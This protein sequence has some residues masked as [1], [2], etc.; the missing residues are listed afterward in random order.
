MTNFSIKLLAVGALALGATAC[1]DNDEPDIPV[2]E[3][4]ESNTILVVNNGVQ[5]TGVPGT[6]TLYN[7]ATGNTVADAF[8]E[9]N[10]LSIGDTPQ[11]AV[12]FG[13]KLY[14]SVFDSNCIWVLDAQSLEIKKSIVPEAPSQG[15]RN[16]A[17]AGDKVYV[18]LYSGHVAA[19]D[20]TAM[21]IES[22]FEV[23]PNPEKIAVRGNMMYVANSDGNNW[24]ES[25][26]NSSL[27]IV[28]LAT[29]EQSF[30]KIGTNVT[31]VVTNGTDVF[32]LCMG[33]YGDIP[34]TIKK[35]GADGTATDFCPGTM[36]AISGSK[37]YVINDPA[38]TPVN[39]TYKIYTTAGGVA[40]DMFAAGT[41]V[42]KAPCGISINNTD[43]SFIILSR[44]M[45]EVSPLYTDPGVAYYY[46][47]DATLR[48]KFDIGINPVA[49]LF[50]FCSVK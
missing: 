28:D 3:P 6:L 14:I 8:R 43:G 20:T 35:I 1:S 47:S 11:D 46:N 17:V 21:A 38:M 36:I 19:I 16:F 7:I 48:A 4:V 31:S 37:L 25:N 44:L 10:N 26:I 40:S 5:S 22:T 13:S 49:A 9:T 30:H 23:G 41:E 24:M 50:N 34:A 29:M 32:A 39:P 33:N 27:S 2:I 42:P 12:I 15:P 18:S 45:G